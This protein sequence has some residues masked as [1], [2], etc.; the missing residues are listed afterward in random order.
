MKGNIR[1]DKTA[2]PEDRAISRKIRSEIVSM[3]AGKSKLDSDFPDHQ[4]E[5]SSDELHKIA[6]EK[7]M[8]MLCAPYSA[9]CEKGFL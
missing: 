1:V 7:V 5:F 2:P 4:K 9:Q 6:T 3:L 8:E